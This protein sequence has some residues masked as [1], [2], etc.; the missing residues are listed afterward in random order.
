MYL[1]SVREDYVRLVKRVN[2]EYLNISNSDSHESVGPIN[3][4]SF[5]RKRYALVMVDNFSRYTR[6]K[7]LSSKHEAYQLITNHVKKVDKEFLEAK[8]FV[9]RSD[10]GTEF[11][12]DMLDAFCKENDTSQ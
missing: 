7:F 5:G 2:Q 9:L 12:N 11:E 3:V 4:L 10:N 8:V 1:N 6:I